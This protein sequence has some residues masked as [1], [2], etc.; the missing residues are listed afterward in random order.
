[1]RQN[2]ELET[3][4]FEF[5]VNRI[6]FEREVDLALYLMRYYYRELFSKATKTGVNNLYREFKESKKDF[7]DYFFD[8]VDLVNYRSLEG[9]TEYDIEMILLSFMKFFGFDVSYKRAIKFNAYLCAF[10]NLGRENRVVQKLMVE[11]ILNNGLDLDKQQ[12]VVPDNPI[13]PEETKKRGP[14]L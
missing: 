7:Y 2:N 12:E 3:L 4:V 14:K 5:L 13:E 6:A 1:M 10:Y 9:I 8:T 11:D